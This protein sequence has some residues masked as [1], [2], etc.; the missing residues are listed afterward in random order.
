MA[1]DRTTID[2]FFKALKHSPF[3]MIGLDDTTDHSQPMTAQ[4]DD[5]VTDRVWFFTGR[6]NKLAT[7]GPAMAQFV[8]KGHDF[9]ACLHGVLAEEPDRAMIDRLSSRQIDA[10]FPQ[11][12]DDPNLLLLRYDL[13]SAEM[14]QADANMISAVTQIF[15]GLLGAG[16]PSAKHAEI[17]L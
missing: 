15:G 8:A 12:R 7:G 14:W 2:D 17:A 4:I 5:D 9:F 13:D 11:G 10:W 16:S 3:V 6:D 1:D